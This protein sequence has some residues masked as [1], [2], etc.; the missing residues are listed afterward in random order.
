MF[1]SDRTPIAFPPLNACLNNLQK[2]KN[3]LLNQ[4]KACVEKLSHLFG[5]GYAVDA[6]PLGSSQTTQLN[7]LNLAQ[8]FLQCNPVSSIISQIHAAAHPWCI[9]L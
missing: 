8:L 1:I 7:K 4:Q 2:K 3:R 5:Y 9:T 6:A